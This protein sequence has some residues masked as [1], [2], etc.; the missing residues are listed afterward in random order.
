MNA[1]T[2]GPG[3]PS[4]GELA[5]VLAALPDPL[6]VLRAVRDADGAIVDLQYTYLNE[7]GAKFYGLPTEAVL[8]RGFCELFPAARDLG[9]FSAYVS[10][11]ETG[12]PTSFESPPF[13]QDGAA[14]SFWRTAVRFGDGILVL[15]HDITE[16]RRAEAALAAISRQYRLLAENASDFVIQA[17]P[18]GVAT[19][20]S[21]SV[22]AVLG[23]QPAQIV[24]RRAL[25][26]VHP[27]E[28]GTEGTMTARTTATGAPASGRTR[29]R[30]ADGSY[31]WVS[32][33]WR[34][35][36]DDT[37]AVVA[38]VAGIRDVQAEVE[39]EHALAESER[40]YRLIAENAS[41]F[42]V[43]ATPQSVITWASP[44]VAGVLGWRPDELVGR[45]AFSFAHPDELADLRVAA[46]RLAI[47]QSFSGRTRLRCA[48]GSFRWVSRTWRPVADDSGT[49]I[50]RVG[51]FRDVQAEVEAEQALAES[52]QRYRLLAENASD[53]VVQA[54]PEG[55]ISW[56]SPSVTAVL[57]W[58][59]AE[60]IGHDGFEFVHPD[61]LATARAAISGAA[62]T[63]ASAS[64]R[65]LLRCADGSYRWVSGTWRPITD[66]SGT[67]IARVAGLR[68]VQ[69]EVEAEQ[70]LAASEERFRLV[71]ENASDVVV[72]SG[73]DRLVTWV[74]PG[75]TRTLGWGHQDLVGTDLA[76]LMHPDDRA[77]SPDAVHSG[78]EVPAPAGGFVIRMRTKSGDYRWIS[79]VVTRVGNGS[80]TWRGVVT[81][82]RDVDDL[83]HAQQAAQADRDHL[84]ATIDSL[85]DPHVLLE[86]VRDETGQI[87]DFVYLDAN[88]AACA[89][90]GVDHQDL[91]GAR[92]LDLLPGHAGSDV[93]ESYR[94]V[95]ETGEPLVLDDSVYAQ[96]LLGGTERRYDTRAARVGD[97]L[98]LTWRD[99]TERH[100]T[101]QVVATSEERYRLLTQ[102]A[103]DVVMLLTP[104]WCLDWVSDSV[105]E[106]LGWRPPDLVG[107]PLAKFIHP[108]DVDRV[109]QILAD[110]PRSAASMEF[111][112]HRADGSYQWVACRTR[113]KVDQDGTTVAVI[114]AM[115]DIT[116]RKAA[117]AELTFSAN[118]DP[119]TGLANRTM[120]VDEADRALA[121]GQ[122]SGSTTALLMV[123]LDHFKNIN[124]ALGH[125]VGD[126]L[127]RAVARR[128]A[129]S[130]RSVDLVARHGGDEFVVLLRDLD[131]PTHALR[132]AERLVAE[133]RAPVT[134]AGTE[135]YATAS[136]GI[137]SAVPGVDPVRGAVDLIRE[138]DTAMYAA[139]L[140]GRDRV[141]QFTDDL[142]RTVDDRMHLE[143]DLRHALT[144]EE[145][146]VW[147]QPEIDL[148]D[149]TVR[150]VEAL[151]RWHHPA[152]Q[153]REAAQ[154][155]SVAEDS[156]LLLDI[157]AWVL[158]R[159][160]ADAARWATGE[161]PRHLVLRVNL[162]PLEL[163]GPDLLATLD[164]ALRASGLDPGLLC[165]E[166]TETTMLSDSSTVKA[167]LGGIAARGIELAIDDF[168][169]GYGSLTYLRRYPIDVLK[170]DRSFVT[171]ITT[172][173]ND[174]RLVAG[175]VALADRLD[176]SVT[177]E[178]IETADQAEL[179]TSLGCAGAQ[180]F[181]Y[182]PALTNEA[183]AEFLGRGQPAPTP[184]RS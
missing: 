51:G 134:I 16:Q 94:R 178:G 25:D 81:G 151:L 44:S 97:G 114:G 54:S 82:W 9:I 143:S 175:V 2:R 74:S 29:L 184:A 87:V 135:L 111:R 153:V 118:H 10:V 15:V 23:W 131:D 145:L 160:C 109:R 170:I 174:H 46:G 27:D 21:P 68:D 4:T 104:G 161:A 125:S 132:L 60:V 83:V 84:R 96:E 121:A 77:A 133:S 90:N 22:T 154:F 156:G 100:A 31:R 138:A 57:G 95:V 72:L 73:P 35:I 144:R 155:I 78:S 36:T 167:N 56:V 76:D 66:D 26:L 128:I 110:F 62:A 103:S 98:S 37:G 171:H 181:L 162:S 137:A 179:L 39:A 93:M 102:N 126:Q 140:A 41:D 7:S 176:I 42:V 32:G 99:V 88:P 119:L 115:I 20:V 58:Q 70:A 6:F 129:A 130:V 86:A 30:C 1:T 92:L 75:V 124:D 106:I 89:Y 28:L 48:N 3:P 13:K 55:L 80:G 147:Y 59:A 107:H 120:L 47:G 148:H 159:A 169:T 113:A 158:G 63:G 79:R 182:A 166:I 38:H 71:A 69:T 91:V 52:E 85:L 61:Q 127:L 33:T 14:G 11:I 8:D 165:V 45:D 5:A 172:D 105:T 24:G 43:Q 19:W 122:R 117:E 12:S 64:D 173:I 183:L 168:G 139:K 108:E 112:F 67:V 164:A 116:D 53:L 101:A 150:A 50:T 141:A 136:V 146:A 34:P 40:R 49:V 65:V 18:D 163:S 123:D 157:G 177:A 152:G 17:S 180:G 142:R 149:G